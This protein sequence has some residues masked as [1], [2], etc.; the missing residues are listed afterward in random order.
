MQPLLHQTS[1]SL[2]M[3]ET[4]HPTQCY[5]DDYALDAFNAFLLKVNNTLECVSRFGLVSFVNNKGLQTY[6]NVSKNGWK[7]NINE[8]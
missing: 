6:I 2:V 1:H 3:S 4:K 5:L 8:S 7:M